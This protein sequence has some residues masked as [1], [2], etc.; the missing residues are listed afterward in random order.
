MIERFLVTT[1]ATLILLIHT[2]AYALKAF[3]CGHDAN[4][5]YG[6]SRFETMDVYRAQGVNRPAMVIIHGGGW[7]GGDKAG[8]GW[9][10]KL[11]QRKGITVF[12][13]NYR[14]ITAGKPETV[15]PAQIQDV[16]HVVRMIRANAAKCGIDPTRIC[17]MGDSAGGHLAMM[18]GTLKEN[19]PGDR[20]ELNAEQSPAVSCVVDMFGPTDLANS[21]FNKG[22]TALLGL[23]GGK[24]VAQAPEI[25]AKASPINNVTSKSATTL[26]LHGNNDQIV[27]VAQATDF[28]SVLSAKGVPHQIFVFNGRHWEFDP[29]SLKN[30]IDDYLVEW[31]RQFL[32]P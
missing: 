9:Y 22:G 19:W 20:S 12:N 18:L 14:L 13:V 27:P 29:P 5:Q 28:A 16:Q 17:A 23:F 25:Y 26:I 3:D 21:N 6:P 32:K 7:A 31:V 10:A 4:Q 24:S 11:F 30:Q 8:H 2:S 1:A 15:W